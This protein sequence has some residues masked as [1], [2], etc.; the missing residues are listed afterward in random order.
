[1]MKHIQMSAKNPHKI[2]HMKKIFGVLLHVVV[3]ML[4]ISQELLTSDY[5]HKKL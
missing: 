4:N 2:M 3:K 5:Y 1:M